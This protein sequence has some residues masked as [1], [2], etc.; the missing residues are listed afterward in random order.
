[1]SQIVVK[2]GQDGSKEVYRG[3]KGSNTGQKG[4]NGV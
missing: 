2:I 4:S 3:E 1:M